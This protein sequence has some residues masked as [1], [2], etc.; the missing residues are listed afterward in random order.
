LLLGRLGNSI[1]EVIA[2]QKLP[3]LSVALLT[4]FGVAGA[5]AAGQATQ[6]EAKAMTILWRPLLPSTPNMVPGMTAIST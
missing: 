6:D 4:L 1:A 5:D 3:C 2:M